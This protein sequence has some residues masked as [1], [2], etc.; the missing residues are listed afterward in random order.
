MNKYLFFLI[1]AFLLN[2]NPPGYTVHEDKLEGFTDIEQIHLLD[3]KD[4]NLLNQSGSSLTFRKHVK[5]NQE[6]FFITFYI[7]LKESIRVNNRNSLL[8]ATDTSKKYFSAIQN[9]VG[10]SQTISKKNSEII[11]YEIGKNDILNIY[12]STDHVFRLKGETSYQDYCLKY[13]KEYLKKFID[14]I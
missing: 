6:V 1:S 3:F 10:E 9:T 4:S 2:C 13:P 12:N 8:I 11:V 7:D 14:R 5:N